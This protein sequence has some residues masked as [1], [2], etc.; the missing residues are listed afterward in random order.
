MTMAEGVALLE[1]EVRELIR[2]R[3]LDPGRD[4]GDVQNLIRDAVADYDDRSLQG[5]V[6]RLD[7]LDAAVKS[8]RDAV[9]GLGALQQHL[10]DPEVEEVWINAPGV[11]G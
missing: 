2:R 5:L 6:P 1:G 4:H 8:V 10:D 11:V 3:G 9:V 7:D